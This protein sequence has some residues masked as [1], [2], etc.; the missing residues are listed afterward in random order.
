MKRLVVLMGVLFALTARPAN[1]AVI[2]AYD[3]STPYSTT[4]LTGFSTSGDGMSGMLVTATIG[5]GADGA[6]WA[7]T[8]AG[9][10]GATGSGWSVTEC[11]DTFTSSW[12]LASNVL[13]TSLFIDA[14][15]G[16][17]V[18][19]IDGTT[20]GTAGSGLGNAFSTSYTGNITATY[21]GPVGLTGDAPVGDLYRFLRLDFTG[22]AF[23]GQLSFLQ[24]TDNLGRLGDITPAPEPAS[25]L[26]LGTGVLAAAL[27]RRF[28]RNA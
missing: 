10:G 1:A 14:G 3:N 2:Y 18:F 19:D 12:T 27:R 5:A 4:S 26:L 9:C 7:T 24:D 17:T 6:T 15:A 13:I 11:G 21:S 23:S 16:N 20:T 28:S 22:G 25:M 8:S